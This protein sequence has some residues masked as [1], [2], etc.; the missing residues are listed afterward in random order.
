MINSGHTTYPFRNAAD[1]RS[2]LMLMRRFLLVPVVLLMLLLFTVNGDVLAQD[3]GSQVREDPARQVHWAMGSFF[4][5]GW[6]QVDENRT[7]YLLRI[8]PPRQTLRE[9]SIDEN[10]N[11]RLGIEFQ[12]PFSL[13]LQKLDFL[14]DTID[15]DNFATVSFTP[16]VQ[17][18]IPVTEK[19]Y[20]RPYAHLGWGT[21]LNSSESAWIYAGGIKSRY[22]LG[23]GKIKWSLLNAIHYAGYS[24]DFDNSGEYGS[25]MTGLE[26]NQPLK[27]FKLG[28]DDTLLNWHVTYN[29]LFDNL[30]FYVDENQIESINDTWELGLALGKGKKKLKIWFMSFEHVGLS[31]KQSSNG[32]Y[33][34][35][36]LNTRSPFTY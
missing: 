20:L 7:V 27:R 31:F 26:F 22:R 16:G 13:G 30:D 2:K 24:P 6:Y 3:D 23:N 28:G 9:S 21:E 11:R 36:S 35:I 10:G 19:W 1:T 12:Y 32:N 18:E 33:R 4:G 25:F 17:V 29:Y 15:S 34:A 5:T 14:Q 8:V